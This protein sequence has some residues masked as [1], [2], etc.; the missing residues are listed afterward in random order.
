MPE[1]KI[2]LTREA[3]EARHSTTSHPM[4]RKRNLIQGDVTFTRNRLVLR[5]IR[6][7]VLE[8]SRPSIRVGRRGCEKVSIKGQERTTEIDRGRDNGAIT[9]SQRRYICLLAACL[10]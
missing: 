9:L 4:E 10:H 3:V 8:E 2:K 7:K 5:E 1:I 6:G